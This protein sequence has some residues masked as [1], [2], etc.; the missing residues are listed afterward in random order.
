MSVYCM[1]KYAI[2]FLKCVINYV[3]I[4][5]VMV[6]PLC[7]YGYSRELLCY[8]GYS[9]KLWCYYGY[10]SVYLVAIETVRRLCWP[11]TWPMSSMAGISP[12]RSSK[13]SLTCAVRRSTSSGRTPRVWWPCFG[14]WPLAGSLGSLVK[15]YDTS[16]LPSFLNRP[17]LRLRLPSPGNSSCSN[18][19]CTVLF[20]SS[21]TS[22]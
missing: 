6:V 10:K 20:F 17:T 18:T 12:P 3:V 7:Y 9:R 22:C 16:R 15:L 5:F 11:R 1:I 4:W 13:T 21:L 8:Y 2:L 19:P 14:W